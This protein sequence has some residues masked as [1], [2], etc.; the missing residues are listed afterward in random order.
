MR[1]FMEHVGEPRGILG[2]WAI[3]NSPQKVEVIVGIQAGCFLQSLLLYKLLDELR[4]GVSFWHCWPSY[5]FLLALIILMIS[6]L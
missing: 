5:P 6:I 4:C 1:E 2:L 3:W